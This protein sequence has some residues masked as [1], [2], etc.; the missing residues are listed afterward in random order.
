MFVLILHICNFI[1]LYILIHSWASNVLLSVSLSTIF[2]Q[3]N[4]TYIQRRYIPVHK[5]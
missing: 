1:T 2:I 4:L 5:Y 3:F